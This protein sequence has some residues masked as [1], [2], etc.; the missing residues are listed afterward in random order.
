MNE[1]P[2]LNLMQPFNGEGFTGCRSIRFSYSSAAMSQYVSF[3]NIKFANYEPCRDG[4]TED[5]FL[6]VLKRANRYQ[7]D[8]NRLILLRN[9]QELAV[10]MAN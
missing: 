2:M 9:S 10:F 3:R 6:N 8:G 4:R 1:Q 7:V 5:R